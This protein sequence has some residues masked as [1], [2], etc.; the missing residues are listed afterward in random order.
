MANEL[1]KQKRDV[2]MAYL[3]WLPS[4]VGFC[5]LHRF[6]AGR[7]ISGLVW[8]FT[9]GLCGFGQLIDLIFIPR[10]IEDINEGREVW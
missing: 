8:F 10:M 3:L 5:G 9:F 2:G 1:V 4:W 7:W 6:Y